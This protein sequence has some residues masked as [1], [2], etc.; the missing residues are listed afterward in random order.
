MAF[1]TTCAPF[2]T[3][4]NGAPQKVSHLTRLILYLTQ[5]NLKFAVVRHVIY[6]NKQMDQGWTQVENEIF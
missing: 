2:V 6:F 3:E 4:P 1:S 5:V